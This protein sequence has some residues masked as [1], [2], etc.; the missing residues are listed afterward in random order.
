M[1]CAGGAEGKRKEKN[2]G[3]KGEGKNK[4]AEKKK[5]GPTG[6]RAAREFLRPD[7]GLSTGKK[8]KKKKKKGGGAK[9]GAVRYVEKGPRG[10]GRRSG[11]GGLYGRRARLAR[12]GDRAKSGP[13]SGDGR[14]RGGGALDL[15]SHR[16]GCIPKGGGGKQTSRSPCGRGGAGAAGGKEKKKGPGGAGALVKPTQDRGP[17]K[18]GQPGGMPASLVGHRGGGRGWAPKKIW[19]GYTPPTISPCA[20][21]GPSGGEG[22]RRVLY[23]QTRDLGGG[24]AGEGDG[25]RRLLTGVRKPH[26][27][28]NRARSTGG[29]RDPPK[30]DGRSP[31]PNFPGFRRAVGRRG[32]LYSVL[33]QSEERLQKPR[34]SGGAP[35]IGRRP[36]SKAFPRGRGVGK[37]Q[38]ALS[39]KRCAPPRPAGRRHATLGARARKKVG[40]LAGTGGGH[41]SPGF[42]G[43]KT[44]SLGEGRGRDRPSPTLAVRFRGLPPPGGAFPAWIALSR[45]GLQHRGYKGFRRGAA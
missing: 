1:D 35:R 5:G 27:R 17:P 43:M 6:G 42:A 39:G 30:A 37:S 10:V 16:L 7:Y 11:G 3:E 8:S 36:R 26:C 34:M 14:R 40:E 45:V 18:S 33:F 31:A 28:K 13:R 32:P 44:F 19:R 4:K 38:G 21:G 22:G 9:K 25:K 12:C 15:F 24:K 41:S 20:G 23:P 2:K 29:G